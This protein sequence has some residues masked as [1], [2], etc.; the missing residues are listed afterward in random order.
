MTVR[1]LR[2]LE[3]FIAVAEEGHI[4]RAADRLHM[5]QPPLTRR[6]QRLEAQ[7]GVALFIRE[8]TGMRLTSAGEV[9]LDEAHQ[10][11]EALDEGVERT[12]R[13]DAGEAGPLV[14]GSFGSPVFDLLPRLVRAFR[15]EHPGVEV[16]F[17]R[18]AK[19][20][21]AQSIRR[22]AIHLG[23]GRH[24]RPEAD[25]TIRQIAMDP[26][27]VAVPSDHPFAER[28]ELTVGDLSDQPVIL[29]PRDRPSFAD[30]IVNLCEESGFQ[31][32]VVREAEAAT[33]AIA[34]VA[35]G[36]GMTVVP[37]SALRIRMDGVT[38]VP[39][40]GETGEDF[41]CI[42]LADHRQP[43]VTAML[44]F[45]DSWADSPASPTHPR[46]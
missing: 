20:D 37:R 22:G 14:V 33:I 4:G 19:S 8:P 43:V 45:L 32:L 16:F 44:G 39:L 29:Y 40:A 1:D 10:V 26:L 3:C 12:R 27:S 41:S 36:H 42:H 23:F 35:V 13:V 38:F 34:Y 25:I 5:T 31:P 2:Q 11:L 15:R 7:L 28:T 18:V 21:Q 30:R 9:L 46:V 17:E 24:Y 6:V